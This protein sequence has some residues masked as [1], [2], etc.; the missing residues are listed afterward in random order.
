MRGV[1][2]PI[3]PCDSLAGAKLSTT[4][5]PAVR[6]PRRGRRS[7]FAR[8]RRWTSWQA[9]ASQFSQQQST[10]GTTSVNIVSPEV[11]RESLPPCDDPILGQ[12]GEDSSFNCCSLLGFSCLLLNVQSI[13]SK[14]KR[15]M[16]S[17]HRERYEPDF[18]WF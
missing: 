14:V 18:F 3:A 15:A 1:I 4:A 13:I 7:S 9:R 10:E 6:S 8:N 5:A 12:S 11:P 16:L 17:A 2:N